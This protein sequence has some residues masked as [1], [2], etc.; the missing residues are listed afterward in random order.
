MALD[1]V[2]LGILAEELRRQLIGARVDKIFMHSRDA[3]LMHVRNEN[4]AKRLLFS[5]RSGMARVH[6]TEETFDNP[7]TPPAFCMLLRKYLQSGRIKDVRGV[8]GERI[9][10]FDFD[11]ITEMGDRTEVTLSMEMMGRYSNIVV[12]SAENFVIDALKRIGMAQSD[13]RQLVP[14]IPFRMP[15]QRSGLS[16]LSSETGDLVE[17]IVSCNRPLSAAV[18]E[19]A[20]GIGPVVSREIAF[21]VSGDDTEAVRLDEKAIQT[22]TN[23]IEA[24]KRAAAGDGR[25]L[26]IVCE[27][28]K[29]F[30]FSFIPLTQYRGLR[31]IEF[32]NLSELLDGYYAQ[33]HR[34]ELLQA[35]S[36]GLKRQVDAILERII[37]R[38]HSREQELASTGKAEKLKLYGELLTANIPL[39]KKGMESAEVFD[40]YSDMMVVIPLDPL[41]TP[42]QNAQRYYRDYRKLITAHKVLDGLLEDGRREIEYMESVRYA[43]DMAETEAEFLN[44]RIELK[45]SGYLKAYRVP[46]KKQTKTKDI[47]AYQTSDGFVVLAGKNNT[48]ND[49]LSLRTA[50]KSDVWFHVKNGAGSHAVLMTDGKPP[51]DAAMTEAAMIA[52]FHSEQRQSAQVAVDY[53]QLRNVKKAPELRT[54]MVVY[55]GYKTAYVTPDM[56]KVEAMRRPEKP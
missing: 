36:S 23:E 8:D 56:K 45:E 14:G 41:K 21:R 12:I 52:A 13:K 29:P 10:F 5:A 11:V 53:T 48:A 40:Y 50:S 34:T 28:E 25:R 38:Q 15:P 2:M 49:R 9:L 22:L 1:S 42:V 51:T 33:R 43:V 31:V 27:G 20:V 54:G 17:R 18:L 39:L 30:E 46:A 47:Y 24:V 37:R 19:S 26:G 55:S 16:F 6:L 7:A 32:E 4:G 3:V 35:R 44:I